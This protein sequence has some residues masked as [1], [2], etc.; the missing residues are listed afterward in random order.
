MTINLA[1]LQELM[2]P[3]N[4]LCKKEKEVNIS[5]IKV[6]LRHLNPQDE[7]EI[8]KL[9]PSIQDENVSGIEF[10]DV[11]RRE[12]L[13][14]SIVQVNDLDLRGIEEIETGETLPNGTPVKISKA[15][16]IVQIIG[17]WSRPVISKLF[18]HYGMLSEEIEKEMDES[19]VLNVNDTEL[20][21][22][23]LQDRLTNLDR[24]EKLNGADRDEDL[25]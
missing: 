3:L 15:E 21:K 1:Q 18:E 16:A 13:C 7:I 2:S 23:N 22:E 12:T 10:A 11:F 8:Q 20:E 6:V 19:L 17:S 24:T 9:L 14:R 25:P 4:E 5:G